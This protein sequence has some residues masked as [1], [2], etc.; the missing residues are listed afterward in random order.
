MDPTGIK[1]EDGEETPM[2][3]HDYLP[4][5][6]LASPKDR[7]APEVFEAEKSE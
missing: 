5:F 3:K 6:K 4:K 7:I 2:N 1:E